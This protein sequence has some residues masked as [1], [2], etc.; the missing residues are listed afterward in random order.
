M[1]QA[2]RHFLNSESGSLAPILAIALIPMIATLGFSLDYNSAVS[3]KASMQNALDAATLSITTL[4]T[5][6]SLA[7]RQVK[8]Q[9]S[10]AANSGEGAAKLD[11]FVVAADGTA[12]INASAGFAMP[13]NFI[14]IAHIPTV[15]IGVASAV[16]KRPALVEATFKVDKVSGY[17]N[18]TMRLYGT[19]FSETNA[20]S[21]M[22][23]DYTFQSYTYTYKIGNRNYSAAE[24]KGYGT[25][26]V[27]T[28]NGSMETK[29]QQQVCTTVGS[30]TS[31][32]TL[33]AGSFSST[34]TNKN[35][36]NRTIYFK[37]T[38][39]TTNFPATGTGAV[40]NVSQ[41]N[42]LYLQMD[43]PSGNPNKLKS[44]DTA[45]SNRLYLDGVEV[46]SGQP[47][48]IFTA[49]PCGQPSSQAWE[50]GGSPVPT[51]AALKDTQAD[52]FYTV[53]GKCGF[54]QRPSET[55]LTQ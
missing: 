47:V 55:M 31:F 44:D 30:T 43:V 42:R 27:Y 50:D 52:F 2:G 18:K 51:A 26:T 9:E 49:V 32:G 38:C 40:I 19:K 4:P 15:Q 6:T 46:A 41:M 3:T 17:W 54:N 22:K 21:L 29:V 14:Q 39:A 8:L 24:P 34:T 37:I 12:T 10:F 23:I 16:R 5:D 33:P 25:S 20:Q 48:D 1:P 13:T 11:G 7:D 36:N 53:T 35:D 28:V 45:T